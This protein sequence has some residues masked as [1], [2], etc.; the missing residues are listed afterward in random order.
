MVGIR[1]ASVVASSYL[2]DHLFVISDS[3][4][5]ETTER[6]EITGGRQLTDIRKEAR[7]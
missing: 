5:Q 1:S 7:C 6:N 2:P 3:G 4:R